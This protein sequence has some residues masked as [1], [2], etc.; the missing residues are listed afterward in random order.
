M[1]LENQ[2]GFAEWAIPG[3]HLDRRTV[4]LSGI[5]RLKDEETWI[6]ACLSSILP[7][8]D[9]VVCVIQPCADATEQVVRTFDD[10]R[11]TVAAYPFDTH[12]IG[13]GHDAC[14]ADSVHAGA[15]CLNWALA[16]TT[17]THVC[18][19]DGDMAA[20][21][22]L[23][24]KVRGLI[25]GGVGRIGFHG[26]DIVSGDL[27]YVG[28]AGKCPVDGVYRVTPDSFYDQGP[29]GPR[30]RGV[31][32]ARIIPRPAFLRFR[33]ARKPLSSVTARWPKGWERMAHFKA[34]LKQREPAR[35]YTGEYP[36]SVQPLV[37]LAPA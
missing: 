14:P 24:A 29:T 17:R 18:A 23:G 8:F 1:H 25:A 3:N 10:P 16:R 6:A 12:S 34:L 28:R 13:P 32:G 19:W 9:E 21:D 20:M 5:V 22:W 15:Y 4:G 30:L 11:I 37:M 7:W 26:L 33:W 27:R 31:P 36:T 2:E 35:F